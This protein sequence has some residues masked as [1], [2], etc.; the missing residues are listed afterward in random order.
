MAKLKVI[1]KTP[2]ELG[3]TFPAEWEPHRGTWFSW[4]RPEGISFPDKYHTVPENLARIIRE[5]AAREEVHINV[6]NGNYQ[7]IVSEQL[8]GNGCGLR[9]VFFHQIK[10][11]ES[12]CRD[13]GPAFV[14]K[15]LP[16]DRRSRPPSPGER[17]RH[18]GGYAPA[19]VDWGF[20]AWGG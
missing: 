4:P 1:E 5:I 2:A 12:W 14:V 7:R 20:K 3:Y 17:R 16:R 8:K 11:N 18:R 6:P 10:T 19:L 9:N 13:H 15:P